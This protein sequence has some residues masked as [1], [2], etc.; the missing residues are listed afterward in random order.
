M[1]AYIFNSGRGLIVISDS[2]QYT[3]VAPNTDGLVVSDSRSQDGIAVA[4]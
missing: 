1:N 4:F 3:I 2:C